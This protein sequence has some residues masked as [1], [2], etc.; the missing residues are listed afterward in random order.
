MTY[1][2]KK[3]I[4]NITNLVDSSF[5]TQT[6]STTVTAYDGTEVTYTPSDDATYVVLEVSAQIGYAP[7]ILSFPNTRLQESTDNGASWSDLVGFKLFE[8]NDIGDYDTRGANWIF[9]LPTW[10]GSKKLRLAGRSKSVNTE[11]GFGLAWQSPGGGSAFDAP[12]HLSIYS[13]E[14]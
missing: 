12:P 1:V 11:F 4:K 14:P 6:I 2:P 10:S 5:S 13:W 8:G 7:D 9:T 3:H